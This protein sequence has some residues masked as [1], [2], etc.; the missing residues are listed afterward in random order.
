MSENNEK[1]R[2]SH[3][4]SVL[5]MLFGGRQDTSALEEEMVQTPFK[6]MM[7][8]FLERRL[9]R[10]G[11]TVFIVILLACLILPIFMNVDLTHQDSSQTNVPP[12]MHMMRYPREL[13]G[14]AQMISPGSNFAV[15]LSNDGRMYLWGMLDDRLRQVPGG[16]GTIV[17]VAA[18]LDHVVAMNDEGQLFTWG[19]TSFGLM[20]IP[21]SA[22]NA[23]IVALNS[24]FQISTALDDEGNL[25]VWGNENMVSIITR[26]LEGR[27]VEWALNPNT[28]LALMDDG[29]VELLTNRN[30]PQ[31]DIPEHIHGRAI[32]VAMT[33]RHAAVVLDDGT[34]VVWGTN[35]PEVLEVP[36]EIQGRV[37][38]IEGARSHFSVILNDNTVHSWGMNLLGQTN[39][40]ASAGNV[41]QLSIA[42]FQNYAIDADGNI[43]TWGL[44]GYL[45][46]TDQ[47]GR[48]V[49]TRLIYGGRFSL[50]V[51][52]IAV[53]I[54][55]TIG[56]IL[57][58]ISGYY[59]GTI[60]MLC[61]RFQEIVSAIPFLPFAIILSWTIGNQL[62]PTGR[63]IAIMVILGL[64]SWPPIMRLV[65]GQVLQAKEN[66]Y[67]TAARALGVREASIVFKHIFPN[68]M[69]VIIVQVT[70]GLAL[71]MLTESG[72][73]FIGFGVNEPVPTWG[74]MLNGANNSV[75]IRNHWWRV[76]FPAIALSSAALAINIIGDGLREA[77][78]PKA[79]GR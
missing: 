61:M 9:T 15:G 58:C 18:G 14:N 75:V 24:G 10:V 35:D 39:F 6:T 37:V 31:S 19:N 72:L 3:F 62:S 76:L 56:I 52:A 20:N 32:D 50:L 22:Q 17:D 41:A 34:V 23:N 29:R 40:P 51:G 21:L 70:I 38:S 77:V 48:D 78:D 4:K 8:N 74:N 7:K 67:I 54:S 59:G 44:R 64:L 43:H 13:R 45:L 5:R 28:A 63:M 25:H 16:M 42:Y 26:G 66:E 71:A 57:G 69:G 46:G 33:D 79:Q 47:F 53:I 36:Q 60:D 12:G 73:S 49:F 1:K 65:R 55:S 30:L 2:D 27:I 68:I 11:L